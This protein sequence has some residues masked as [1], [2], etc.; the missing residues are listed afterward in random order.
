VRDS[1]F[2]YHLQLAMPTSNEMPAGHASEAI[3]SVL[4]N[5]DLMAQ[6]YLDLERSDLAQCVRVNRQ[7]HT[8]AAKALYHTINFAG[9]KSLA[10]SICGVSASSHSCVILTNPLA[11]H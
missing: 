9:L 1:A 3:L 5:P 4:R 6:V 10:A 8:S 7:M 2:T 11:T